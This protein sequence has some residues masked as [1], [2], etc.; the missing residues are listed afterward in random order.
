MSYQQ[1]TECQRKEN[2][3]TLHCTP[4]Q[5]SCANIL[6]DKVRI[7]ELAIEYKIP[8]NTISTW[9]K[10]ADKILKDIGHLSN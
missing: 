5:K 2:A 4:K 7:I 3:R 10:H 9:K 8:A 1:M 6:Y